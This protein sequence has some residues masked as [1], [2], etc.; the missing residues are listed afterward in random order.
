MSN[1]SKTVF[2]AQELQAIHGDN[3]RKILGLVSRPIVRDKPVVKNFSD[4]SDDTQQI[5]LKIARAIKTATDKPFQLWAIGS[6]IKGTWR[7]KEEEEKIAADNN[8]K[9]KYSDYDYT[10]TGPLPTQQQFEQ[11]G[12]FGVKLHGIVGLPPEQNVEIPVD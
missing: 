1:L 8:L 4:F 5:Y 9:I 2:T 12:L 6:R 3:W 7:T 10:T 11:V